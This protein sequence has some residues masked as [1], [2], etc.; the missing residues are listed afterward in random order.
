MS[1]IK[2]HWIHQASHVKVKSRIVLGVNEQV[3]PKN[4][5]PKKKV[6]VEV[7]F[8][9]FRTVSH[10]VTWK[11]WDGQNSCSF[12]GIN[13]NAEGAGIAEAYSLH[14]YVCCALPT[15]PKQ[16]NPESWKLSS[17][18]S[19][20]FTNFVHSFPPKPQTRPQALAFGGLTLSEETLITFQDSI[21]S[22]LP[23]NLF[24]QFWLEGCNTG[25]D[26]LAHDMLEMGPFPK[27]F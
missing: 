27:V 22:L 1:V 14:S 4:M 18:E 8:D 5:P 20:P 9:E 24:L 17:Q 16:Q 12:H 23:A 15:V 11:W 2:L 6:K 7:N 21:L 10:T 19:L 26:Y 25:Y 3:A 13:E